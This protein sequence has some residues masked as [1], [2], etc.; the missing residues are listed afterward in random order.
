MIGWQDMAVLGVVLAA[1]VLLVRHLWRR[2]T[3]VRGCGRDMPCHRAE[4]RPQTLISIDSAPTRKTPPSP[5]ER[6]SE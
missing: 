2:T 5:P 1:A 3:R 4:K 6:G